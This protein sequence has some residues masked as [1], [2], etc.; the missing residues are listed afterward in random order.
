MEKDVFLRI[1]ELMLDPGAFVGSS[2]Y[3]QKIPVILQLVITLSGAVF[4]T[5]MLITAIGS[6]VSNRADDY[7]KGRVHYYFHDHILILGANSM[8]INMLREKYEESRKPDACR[9]RKIVILTTQDTEK[10]HDR[11]ASSIPG[12]DR[13]LDVTFLNGSRAVEVTLRRLNIDDV[14]SIYIFGEEEE[15]DHDA[16]NLVAWKIVQKLC[17][18]VQRN[19]DCYMAVDRISTYHVFQFGNSLTHSHLRLNVINSLEA[20]AQRVL[21]SREYMC[22]PKKQTIRYPAI[23]RAGIGLSSRKTVRF[24]VF[25]M[26][27]MGY[28]MATTVAHIAHFPNFTKDTSLKTKICFIAPGIRQ[29]MDFFMGHYSNLFRLSHARYVS[30]DEFGQSYS[31]EICKPAPA[32]G[33]FLDIEWEFYDSSIENKNVRNLLEMWTGNEDEYLTISICNE[34]PDTNLAAS[35]Y[36][37]EMLYTKDIPVFVYLSV[38]DEVLKYAHGTR[39]YHNIYPFGMKED[40]YDP[41]FEKRLSMAKKVNYLYC[42]KDSGHEFKGMCKKDELDMYWWEKRTKREE[43][44][45]LFSN[46]YAANSIPLKLRS[47]GIDPDDCKAFQERLSEDDVHILAE[48]EHNRWNV[49][50]LLIGFSAMTSKQ[51]NELNDMLADEERREAGKKLNNEKRENF[52]HKDLAPYSELPDSTKEYDI[53]IVR[54]I[55]EVMC[56]AK[57]N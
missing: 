18:E 31:Q 37:P 9:C 16:V 56:D 52:I 3:G 45:Y 41:L 11:I 42:L 38:V 26:T 28:S 44:A 57:K 51:R 17:G 43:Y 21:V 40:T 49:E 2:K 30:W 7:R 19:I 53:A 35:L 34:E 24:V 33:D 50:R 14:H 32:Y 22:M 48:V 10:L 23:D 8:A 27:P 13:N 5:A 4:F 15:N 47:V 6:I 55:L 54:N 1:V 29:E 12:F 25:G 46:L 20:W 39:R 36:L